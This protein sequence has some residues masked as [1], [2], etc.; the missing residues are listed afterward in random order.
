M[1]PNEPPD[2]T[3]ANHSALSLATALNLSALAA[4]LEA[5]T[6]EV[7]RLRSTHLHDLANLEATIKDLQNQQTRSTATLAVLIAVAQG[8]AAA[9]NHFPNLFGR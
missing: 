6:L 2:P 9:L 4:R 3:K 5:L 8:T 1:P 7:D